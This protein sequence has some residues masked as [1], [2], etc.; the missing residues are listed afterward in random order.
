[1][2]F[3]KRKNQDSAKLDWIITLLNNIGLQLMATQ[4][5]IDALTAQVN[6]I[7][8]EVKAASATLSAEIA[9]LQAIIDAGN[10]VLDLSALQAAVQVLDDLTP[11][12]PAV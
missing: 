7:D 6:K 1:M 10:P 4:T 2:N 5:D 9:K 11:D 3:F 8:V 12:V